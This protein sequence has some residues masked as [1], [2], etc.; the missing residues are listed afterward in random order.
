[1]LPTISHEF[2]TIVSSVTQNLAVGCHQL[3]WKDF[4]IQFAKL[5]M[6][7]KAKTLLVFSGEE[8]QP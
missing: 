4:E 8:T 5:I 2:R 7:V 1:M 6:V 3:I